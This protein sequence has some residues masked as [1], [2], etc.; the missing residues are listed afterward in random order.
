MLRPRWLKIPQIVEAVQKAYDNWDG[1]IGCCVRIAYAIYD[2]LPKTSARAVV[3]IER[4]PPHTVVYVYHRGCGIKID[5]D[6][7]MY[8]KYL[9]EGR[10]AHGDW[11]KIHGVVFKPDDV[12]TTALSVA[13]MQFLMD[14]RY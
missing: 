12:K 9:G 11:E 14:D 3:D 10:G 7:S 1:G 8:E 2:L 5:I 4:I 6:W 13:S